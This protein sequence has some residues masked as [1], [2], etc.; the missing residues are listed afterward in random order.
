M[1]TRWIDPHK[2][3]ANVGKGRYRLLNQ[4][5]GKTLAKTINSPRLKKYMQ[6]KL[7]ERS[8]ET[9]RKEKKSFQMRQKKTSIRNIGFC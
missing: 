4:E 2:I 6:R 7:D 8:T 3:T 1:D 5:S 9:Q